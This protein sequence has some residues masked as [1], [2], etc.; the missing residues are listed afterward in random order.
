M[1]LSPQGNQVE[2]PAWIQKVNQEDHQAESSHM[3]SYD[4]IMEMLDGIETGEL[5]N[6]CSAEQLDKITYYVAFLAKEGVLPDESE[7]SL[8]L[9]D[10]IEKLLDGKENPYEYAFYHGAPRDFMIAS[11]VVYNHRDVVLCKS[12]VQKQWKQTKKF[13]KK[14]KK[15]III[16]AAVVVAAAAIIVAV[17]AAPAVAAGAAAAGATGAAGAVS[18]SGSDKSDEK[19]SE[20]SSVS[21]EAS[22]PT[23]AAEDA[24]TLK[25]TI[26]H[27]ISSF[28][29]NIVEQ[30]FFHPIEFSDHPQELSWEENGRTLGSIFAHDSLYNIQGQISSNPKLA[31]EIRDMQSKYSFVV[32]HGN[33]SSPATHFGID[34]SFSTNYTDLYTRPDQKVN[35]NALSYQ[36]RGENALESGYFKQ[37]VR[38]LG[39]S[40][41]FNPDNPIPYLERGVAHFGLGQYD[42]CLE[43]YHEFTIQFQKTYPL[44]VKDFSLGFAK[45]LPKGI[46]DSGEGIFLFI[47]DLIVHPIHTGA[48][49]FEALTMLATLTA[50][51]QWGAISEVLAPEIRQLVKDWHTIPSDQRGELAGYAFG[52]YG[53]D[54]VLPGALTKAV[55]KGVKG[56]REI[57][58]V[59]RNLQT[60]K[61]TLVLESVGGLKSGAKVAEVV[62][63]SQRTIALGEELGYSAQH[64]TQLKQAGKLEGTLAKNTEWV[65]SD[66]AMRESYQLFE[67]AQDFLKPYKGF[68]TEVECRD[69][70]H[71]AGV[72]TFPRPEGIP[73]NFRVK[74]SNGGAGMLYVHPK[75]THTSVRVMPGKPNSPFPHQQETYVIQMKNGKIL[76]KN[77]KVV[78]TDSPEAHIP[79]KE[80]VYIGVD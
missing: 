56:A 18:S 60:V 32:P 13:C 24:P 16:G 1:A 50:N 29:E 38:D 71:R 3:P 73:A 57:N 68:M 44:V 33:R 65:F 37:A 21:I 76:D 51:A 69:L 9:E 66:P 17:V 27:Q 59:C 10:D 61:K 64:M 41:E 12:W 58:Q 2:V 45:G 52:K 28:K 55:A 53:P 72:R 5:E 40:I 62:Q 35:L 36:V 7:E 34:R 77:N 8:S 54:I 19:E 22:P 67:K 48:Q 11:A 63:T 6:T 47:S 79:I 31:G 78:P 20:S 75:H 42:R 23:A 39:K 49:M 26:D 43:D 15:A 25:S 4:E 46:Y 14:H 70:I 80:F 30:K 74:I